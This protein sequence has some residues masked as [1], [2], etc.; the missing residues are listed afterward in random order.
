MLRRKEKKIQFFNWSV[1]WN[2]INPGLNLG[3]PEPS[4]LSPEHRPGCVL[5]VCFCLSNE[6]YSLTI[7]PFPSFP[8]TPSTGQSGPPP[9]AACA[10]VRTGE[11]AAAPS[12]APRCRAD[13][14]SCSSSR[15]EAA[16]QCVW[17]LGVSMNL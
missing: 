16:A 4:S 5:E 10:P 13:S 11:S 6:S 14:R 1:T 9:R 12:R 3:S 7:N 15:K 2:I 17:A 8:P